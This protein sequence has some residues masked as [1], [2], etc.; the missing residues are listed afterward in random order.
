MVRERLGE[1]AVEFVTELFTKTLQGEKKPEERR[2][3][4]QVSDSCRAVARGT[5]HT[6]QKRKLWERVAGWGITLMF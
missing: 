1:V 4:V 3:S 2:E 6:S 5:P